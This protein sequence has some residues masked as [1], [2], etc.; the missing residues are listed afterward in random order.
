M[1]FRNDI[2]GLRALA[3]LLVFIFHLQKAWLPGGFVGVDVFFVISG[4]L[5]TTIIRSKILKGSFSL[6]D[7]YLSRVSRI[8]PAYY[9]MVFVVSIASLFVYFNFDIQKISRKELIYVIGFASN[10][11]FA[12]LGTYFGARFA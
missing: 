3:V 8:V 11:Y 4:F 12:T 5:I 7:F 6:K 9:F 1:N 2:Q 10:N